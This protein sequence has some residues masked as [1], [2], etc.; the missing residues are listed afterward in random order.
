VSEFAVRRARPADAA[1]VSEV[2][3]E[4]RNAAAG[5]IPPAVHSDAEVRDWI[6]GH[7]L[8]EDECW[9]AAAGDGRIVGMLALQE[10]WIDQLYVAPDWQRSGVGRA[11]LDLAMRIR[12]AGLQLWTFASNEPAR[13]FYERAGFVVAEET[14]GSGNEEK[15]P[16]VR[17]VHRLSARR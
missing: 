6:A 5:L 16:D 15:A 7:L 13:R 4:S 9:V 10:D 2:W 1:G 3:L 11:L 12:P 17:Y 8:I 14:D